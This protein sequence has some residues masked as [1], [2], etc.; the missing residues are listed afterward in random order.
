VSRIDA[1]WT[2]AQ[3]EGLT[4]YQADPRYHPYTCRDSSHGALIATVDGWEC[5]ACGYWQAW[6]HGSSIEATN[7]PW[8]KFEKTIYG[9]E[10]APAD[11][12][13]GGGEG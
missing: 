2:D 4:R 11:A 9:S 5:S 8:T 7:R 12:G 6:A 1:P 3:A 10:H 13:D